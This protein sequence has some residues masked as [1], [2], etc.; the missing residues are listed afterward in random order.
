MDVME[1]WQTK[2]QKEFKDG[3]DCIFA[4]STVKNLL[5]HKPWFQFEKSDVVQVAIFLQ[6]EEASATYTLTLTVRKSVNIFDL[7]SLVEDPMILRKTVDVCKVKTP[8]I[9]NHSKKFDLI[10]N[11][12][13]YLDISL[14]IKKK[15]AVYKIQQP[16]FCVKNKVG[17]GID[18]L[19]IS[20]KDKINSHKIMERVMNMYDRQPCVV[21][22]FHDS[23]LP[24]LQKKHYC[25]RA[26]NV[27]MIDV[28]FF[29]EFLKSSKF[30]KRVTFETSPTTSYL[31]F[32]CASY[33][34][35][36]DTDEA[37]FSDDDDDDNS[38]KTLKRKYVDN[39]EPTPV[40]KSTGYLSFLFK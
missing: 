25:W 27:T 13:E 3:N 15:S 16:V 19:I 5:K 11:P 9:I 10:D 36:A 12:F 22:E 14:I 20:N 38:K 32:I 37:D 6:N 30:I 39:N 1:T 33:S 31:D 18:N 4:Q 23:G 40:K 26:I 35:D 34:D 21:W 8:F 24:E 17:A 28:S 2:I 29:A 7:Y